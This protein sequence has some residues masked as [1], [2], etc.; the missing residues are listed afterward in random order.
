MLACNTC[1]DTQDLV[2][3]PI[4]PNSIEYSLMSR[5]TLRE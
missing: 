5:L 1:G 2:R 4:Q 3:I